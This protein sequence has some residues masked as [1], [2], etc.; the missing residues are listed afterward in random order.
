MNLVKTVREH[1]SKI[2]QLELIKLCVSKG[3]Y[4]PNLSY[5]YEIIATDKHVLTIEELG[6]LLR[7]DFEFFDKHLKRHV[8]ASRV[9]HRLYAKYGESKY[10]VVPDWLLDPDMAIRYDKEYRRKVIF[11]SKLP[12]F[13][14]D[15]VPTLFDTI[16]T[17][18]P[19]ILTQRMVLTPFGEVPILR[20]AFAM[21]TSDNVLAILQK[22]ITLP[23]TAKYKSVGQFS[24]D[25]PELV[26]FCERRKVPTD[27]ATKD[28]LV[29]IATSHT[30]YITTLEQ[31]VA[32]TTNLSEFTANELNRIKSKL[33]NLDTKFGMIRKVDNK[34]LLTTRSIQNII[35]TIVESMDLTGKV[36]TA[37][38]IFYRNWDFW[39]TVR[40][41]TNPLE[42]V[43]EF[44]DTTNYFDDFVK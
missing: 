25:L 2:P 14:L 20:Q 13:D 17:V 34:P 6:T 8:K 31:L 27:P 42:R 1:L 33:I 23:R 9:A 19:N 41:L 37:E 43:A 28:M 10:S 35:T 21:M 4:K 11:N 40:Y 36:P 12:Y 44:C 24:F 29:A 30:P 16:K 26:K 18:R 7:H 39:I 38:T 32:H 15:T 22:V 5:A 3:V